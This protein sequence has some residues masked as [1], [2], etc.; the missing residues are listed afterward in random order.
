[1]VQTVTGEVSSRDLGFVLVHEHVFHDLY[2]VTVNSQLIL[3]DESIARTELAAFKQAGG[4][5][6]VEQTVYGM[7]PDPLALQRMAHDV[8]INIVIGTGFYWERFHPPWL[9]SMN[10]QEIVALLVRDLT[11]GFPGTGIRAG[12]LGEIGSGH[13]AITPAEERVFRAVA[14]AQREVNVPIA[15]HA[16]FTRIGMEQV[17]LLEA[18]GANLDKVVVGH[19]DTVPDVGYQEALLQEGVWIAYDCIGQL[20]K[21]TDEGRADAIMELV[22]R[23]WADRLLLSMD[24][25][26]RGALRS[27]GGGGYDYLIASFLPLLRERGAD[28]E[29]IETLTRFN[30]QRLFS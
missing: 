5:T 13:R 10:E 4:E 15:T 26:K 29:L 16:V 17:R 24:I 20:D 12:L 19:A 28:P 3:N 2:E 25:A 23:G 9:A 1:M 11:D 14:R 7:N 8:G 6:L 21:Q 30:P 22:S 18:S 27:Y